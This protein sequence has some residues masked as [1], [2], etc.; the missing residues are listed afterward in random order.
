MTDQKFKRGDRVYVRNSDDEPWL[1]ATFILKGSWLALPTY[2]ALVDGMP[3]ND[4]F[5]QIKKQ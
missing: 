3:R 4:E 5:S 2:L 1:S